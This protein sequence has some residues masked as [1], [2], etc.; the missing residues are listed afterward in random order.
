ML[1]KSEGNVNACNDVRHPFCVCTVQY[2]S[3]SLLLQHKK[4]KL[5]QFRHHKVHTSVYI[6][7]IFYTINVLSVYLVI[8]YYDVFKLKSMITG[9]CT[10]CTLI[11]CASHLLL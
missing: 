1:A 7:S 8:L 10:I 11:T 2:H 3:L 9:A 6:L 4:I 5:I